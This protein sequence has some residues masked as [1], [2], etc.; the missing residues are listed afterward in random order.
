MRVWW[1]NDGNIF[2][3]IYNI[4]YIPGSWEIVKKLLSLFK[5]VKI[6]YPVQS[7]SIKYSVHI[8]ILLRFERILTNVIPEIEYWALVFTDGYDS[9]NYY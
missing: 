8:L 3:Y 2:I 9:K 4:K 6:Y 7:M 1:H 5:T